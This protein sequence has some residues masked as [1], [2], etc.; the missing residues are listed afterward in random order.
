MSLRPEPVGEIP[1]ETARVARA[2]FP[3]GT[4]VSPSY[5]DASFAWRTVVDR[6]WL[7][8]QYGEGFRTGLLTGQGRGGAGP[9]EEGA[10]GPAQTASRADDAGLL[11][12]GPDCLTV[13]RR[14]LR[15]AGPDPS[16]PGA[17]SSSP[18]SL[19]QP[20]GCDGPA[21]AQES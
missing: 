9:T 4:V 15:A 8:A 1:A 5:N 10:H 20:R 21:D 18:R 6:S 17:D 19:A 3:K 11:Q 16:P 13:P 12:G 7:R 2:A 14:G